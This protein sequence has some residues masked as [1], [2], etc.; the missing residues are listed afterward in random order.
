[1]MNLESEKG[2]D[3]PKGDR[4]TPKQE[5]FCQEYFLLGNAQ[6]AYMRAGYRTQGNAAYTEG[7][8]LLK[9]PLIKARI[10]ELQESEALRYAG[11]RLRLMRELERIAY[12]QIT[13]VCEFKGTS[14]V[15]KNSEDLDEDVRAA[16]AEVVA[17]KTGV[18]VKMHSKTDALGKLMKI[19][20]LSGDLNLAIAILRR[21]GL[22]LV[23]ED[24]RWRLL[25]EQA[26]PEQLE[27]SAEDTEDDE[28]ADE[29][30]SDEEA[31]E[32][33]E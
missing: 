30:D 32:A 2:E 25:D 20:G 3:V 18:A 28:R 10:K 31:E 19:L 1:M 24:G 11:S 26:Q 27:E 7:Y 16:I 8:R 17:T 15:T 22:N 5:K 29:E 6:K 23:I 4:L 33:E 9:N 13:D 12:A 21:Y 14:V